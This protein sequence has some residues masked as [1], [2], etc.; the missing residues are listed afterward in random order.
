LRSG[1]A[2]PLVAATVNGSP[3]TVQPGDLIALPAATQGTFHII[4]RFQ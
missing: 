2:R 4:N 1:D 3:A